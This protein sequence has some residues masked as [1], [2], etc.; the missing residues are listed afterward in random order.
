MKTILL[1]MISTCTLLSPD[2][3]V[4]PEREALLD[5]VFELLEEN[6]ANP[7]W[8]E[9]DTFK[10]FKQEMYSKEVLSMTDEDFLNHF[11]TRRFDLNFSHFDLHSTTFRKKLK[12]EQGE[13]AVMSWKPLNE[14]VAYL[15]VNTFV[16][17]G[18]PMEEMISEIGTDHYK[19]LII[20][21]RNNGGGSLDAPVILGRFLTQQPIDAG[22]YLT[23]SWFL[24]RGRSATAEDVQKMPF[25]QDF[26]YQ[27]IGK[28]FAEQEAFRMVLPP[29]QQPIYKGKVFV[30][31][32]EN[33]A[34]AC[35]PLID[36]LK[37]EGIATLVGSSSAG[38]MLSGKWFQV[39]ENYKVFIP[40]SDYQTADGDRLDKKGVQPDIKVDPN[41]ALDY[42]LSELIN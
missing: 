23:R 24:N 29:H 28:M 14:Q 34:S 30:L 19:H 21:L 15:N 9:S 25:L 18:S 13:Q 20:D 1:L 7:A 11:R 12:V 37:K 31:V 27:G 17:D 41:Q 22:V 33:T 3:S 39:N 2:R 32:N 4:N 10:A 5:K 42:V 26:T 16:T 36:L 38:A 6:V 8:L 40:I 35:E